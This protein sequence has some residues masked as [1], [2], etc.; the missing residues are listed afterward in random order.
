M[1]A[2]GG[3]PRLARWVGKGLA[4]RLAL[5]FPLKADEQPQSGSDGE[6]LNDD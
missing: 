6:F 2:Y 3:G 4:M 5:G 1:P